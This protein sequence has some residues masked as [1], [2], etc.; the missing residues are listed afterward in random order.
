M[1]TTSGAAL[2]RDGEEN[3]VVSVPGEASPAQDLISWSGDLRRSLLGRAFS[4]SSVDL[5]CFGD[6]FGSV[7]AEQPLVVASMPCNCIEGRN[8]WLLD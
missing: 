8:G 2:D 5:E 3:D 4:M 6:L 1:S 7:V